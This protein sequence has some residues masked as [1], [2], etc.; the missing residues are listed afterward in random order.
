MQAQP[1]TQG[2]PSKTQFHRVL[3]GK[4]QSPPAVIPSDQRESRDLHSK[5]KP[6][7]EPRVP[8][9]RRSFIASWV[10]NHNLPPKSSRATQESRGTRIQNASPATNPGCSIQDAVSSRLGWETTISPRSHPERPKGVEGPALVFC[11]HHQQPRPPPTCRFLPS[12]R[13]QLKLE[14]NRSAPALRR[15]Q[16]PQCETKTLKPFQNLP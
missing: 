7:H 2:A 6:S 9:P 5:C 12:L 13:A 4:P 10:G 3:G 8:H 14:F 16:I 11:S 1:R 15:T